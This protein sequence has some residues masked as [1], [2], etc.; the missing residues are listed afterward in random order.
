M[1]GNNRFTVF[2]KPWQDLSL[3]ALGKRVKGLGF[4]GVE[5]AVRPGYQVEPDNVSAGLKE[6]VKILGNEGIAIGSVA[7]PTDEPTI[8][9]C[10]ENGI[11][12]IR[13]CQGVDL[14]IGYLKSVERIRADYDAVVPALE[15]AGVSL[16]VQNHCGN[17]I[18][19]AIG[20]MHL[21][22]KYDPRNI[23]AVLDPAHCAVDG[24]TEE[25]ALDI[26]WSHLSLINFKS[27][28]HRRANRI[29]APEAEW[30]ILW[31]TSQHSGYS[32]RKMV[33]LLKKKGYSGDIC[34]PAEYSKPEGG[35]QLM[36]NDVIPNLMY[37]IQYIKY[38]FA[39]DL[40]RELE[41]FAMVDWQSA[42][43]K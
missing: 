14:E 7:G 29:T 39:S 16:G 22:E 41:P 43:P 28:S 26:V 17:M 1:D 9:A 18:A 11:P 13:I 8:A 4:D 40:G 6:A 25:M 2:T 24:E 34:L 37:D 31:T 38:L 36:G 5:L 20:L 15:A 35:G 30:E 32:W 23:S 21:I 33:S 12:I 3:E 10:G 27:A 42:G 19:S